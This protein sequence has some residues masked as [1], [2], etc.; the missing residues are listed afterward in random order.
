MAPALAYLHLVTPLI[1]LLPLA[2]LLPAP[3][4]PVAE[5]DGIIPI[6]IRKV[7]PRRGAIISLLV[8]LAITSILDTANL[9]GTFILRTELAKAHNLA[10]LNLAAWVVYAFGGFLLWSI[11]TLV[12]EYRARWADKGVVTLAVLAMAMEIPNLVLLVVNLKHAGELK[13]ASALTTVAPDWRLFY[14][15]FIPTSALRLVLLPGLLTAVA[16]SRVT[17]EPAD[18]TSRLLGDSETEEQDDTIA[19]SS[20]PQTAACG[21]FDNGK[22]AQTTTGASTPAANKPPLIIPKQLGELKT[23]DKPLEWRE[24]FARVRKLSPHLWPSTSRRLQ[25]HVLICIVLLLAGRVLQ[26]LLP[27]SLGKVVKVLSANQG[28]QGNGA[29]I[30]PPFI[31]YFFVRIFMSGAGLIYFIRESL[32]IPVSQYTD[33]EMMMLCFNHLLNLSLAYHTKRNT[34]EV[35]KVIDRGSAVNNLFQVVLFT[36]VPTILD[37]VIGFSI[38]FYLYGG[39]LALVS[40]AVM[41]VYVWVSV[42]GTRRRVVTRRLLGERDVKQRGIISDVLTN[43]ESVKYFTSEQRES[44]RYREAVVSYQE[45]EAKWQFD[46]QFL[47]LCQSFLL[48]LGLLSGSLIIAHRILNG[49]ADA[50]E[51]ITFVTYFQQL[52]SPL[53]RL[54]SLYQSLNRTSTDAEKMFNLLAQATEVNDKPGAKDLVVT[55]GVVEFDNVRFSYDGKVTALK[56]VSFKIDKGQSMAL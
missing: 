50:S 34:G 14:I 23:E 11:T 9:V 18:E 54:G 48:S 29:S 12:V 21:T 7:T 28:Q 15:L 36:A 55:D 17:Y 56:G 35:L 32:W 52:S 46:Y 41:A 8:L 20:T 19:G 39:L 44:N 51:F 42:V 24:L 31:L 13:E 2:T 26:P 4:P 27:L 16:N 1:L 5:P 25:L 6:T 30:W 45:M 22:P 37:I 33:R 49:N 38:F 47:Y 3:R 43:W 53:D 10:G 40:I